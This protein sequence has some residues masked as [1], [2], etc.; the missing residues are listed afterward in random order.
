MAETVYLIQPRPPVR[1]FA[2]AAVA[3]LLGAVV[4]VAALSTG[5]HWAWALLG[6]LVMVAGLL[7][8]VTAFMSMNRLAVQVTFD[9]EGYRVS[10]REV[11]GEGQWVDVTKV[12]QTQSGNRVTIHHGP[13]RAT[14]L[15]FPGNDPKQVDEVVADLR[16]RLR[17]VKGV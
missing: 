1:A 5:W 10:G 4:L 2:I 16:G 11:E 8:L 6:G 9:A 12:T 17:A 7:L 3:S 14:Y 15:M 13:E